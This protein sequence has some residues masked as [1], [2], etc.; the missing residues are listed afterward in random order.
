L[1][2]EHYALK[3]KIQNFAEFLSGK[4]ENGQIF[5]SKM[6]NFF[7]NI[8]IEKKGHTENPESIDFY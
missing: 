7:S 1:K 4:S 3:R 6:E 8:K 5:L 2:L